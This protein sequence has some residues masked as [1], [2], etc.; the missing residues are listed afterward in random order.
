LAVLVSEDRNKA[1][2]GK[3]Q[4]YHGMEYIMYGI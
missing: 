1:M 3:E 4:M 2:C